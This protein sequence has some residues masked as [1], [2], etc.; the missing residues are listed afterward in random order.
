MDSGQTEQVDRTIEVTDAA[1]NAD[2]EIARP[3]G[4]CCMEGTLHVGE[5][6]G[7]TMTIAGVETYVVEPP[8][9]KGNGHILLYF[10]DVWGFFNNGFL[11]MDGF[12]DAG[13]L[14]LGLDY[15]RG[16]PVWRH[17]KDR[18]DTTTDP[19]FDYEAWKAKHMAFSDE[20]VPRWI[21]EV[22]AKYGNV[23]AKYACVGYC[24]GAPYVCNSLAKGGACTAGA[25]AHPAFLKESHFYNL[26]KPLFLSCSE[27][28]HTFPNEF[29][30]RAVDIMQAQGKIFQVQL[31]QGVEHGF[32]LRGNIDN[33]YERYTKEQSLKG[34]AEWFDF[35]LSQ[36]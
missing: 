33:P 2:K 9:G 19:G 20:A 15:F 6:R 29:R 12:A 5:P 23:G 18:T 36:K 25:F 26:A 28:D 4:A 17:Q 34:I 10:P 30:N 16:D 3:S 24:Y 13:Y 27:I 8:S 21:A 22:Q 31:F 1:D 7:T 35:W 32:A 11:V 14:T